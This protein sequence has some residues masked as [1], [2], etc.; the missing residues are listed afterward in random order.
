MKIFG[1]IYKRYVRI[2][3]YLINYTALTELF[4]FFAILEFFSVLIFFPMSER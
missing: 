2:V 1:S 3:A 4:F